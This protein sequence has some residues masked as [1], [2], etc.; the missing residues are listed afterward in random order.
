[1]S[2][3]F[4]PNEETAKAGQPRSPLCAATDAASIQ[5]QWE[6]HFAELEDPRGSQGIEHS[7]L[8]IVMIAIV[9]VIGEATGW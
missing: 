7:F 8:S 1:M 4:A 3:G 5:Q 6:S 2:Q 9:G